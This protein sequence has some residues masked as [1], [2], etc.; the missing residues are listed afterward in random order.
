[1]G[2]HISIFIENILQHYNPRDLCIIAPDV[3]GV[4][5]ARAIAKRL[6]T[7]LAIID[8]RR[9]AEAKFEDMEKQLEKGMDLSGTFAYE[10][11]STGS[12]GILGKLLSGILGNR[13]TAQIVAQIARALI[14]KGIRS[15]AR[16]LRKTL[17]P[18]RKFARGLRR[19]GSFIAKRVITPFM[20]N[21]AKI[22][23]RVGTKFGR[24]AIGRLL[25]DSIV[26]RR[27]GRWGRGKLITSSGWGK[28]G[29]ADKIINWK[30]T[31]AT[32]EMNKKTLAKR[33]I[34]IASQ[35]GGEGLGRRL[36][37][38]IFMQAIKSPAVQKAIVE[39]LGKEG[40]E[41][42]GVKL[43]AGGTK[44]GFPIFGTE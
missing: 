41:K 14:P 4:L 18:V 23:G 29:L 42:I 1:M 7:D 33:G 21:S 20:M 34:K 22:F 11:T 25:Q 43:A 28:R 19:P 3:G 13:F 40:A 32:L 24:A 15:R 35:T 16:L 17:L 37:K 10:K 8:K 9:E 44:G 5:R 2:P 6:N 12:Y 31:Q 39:K 30:A 26:T 38:G 36:S 27:F